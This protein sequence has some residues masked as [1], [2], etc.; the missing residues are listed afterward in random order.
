MHGN[1]GGEIKAC[2]PPRHLALTWEFGGQ[3]SWVDVQ[4]T[5]LSTAG[6]S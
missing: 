5:P 4:L 2:D 1:A 6:Q 3:T